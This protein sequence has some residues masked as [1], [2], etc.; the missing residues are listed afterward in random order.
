MPGDG[1]NDAPAL[2]QADC[3]TAFS[4]ATDA[5]RGAAALI[6]AAP[7]LSVIDNAVDEAQL[8]F[9]SSTSYTIYRVALAM[10]IMVLVVLSTIFL[11]F[12]PLTAIMIVIM[13]LL[14]DLPIMTIA[15]DN[16]AVAPRPIRWRMPRLLDVSAVL[17]LASVVQSFGL[18]LFGMAARENEAARSFFE[19]HD[20]SRLQTVM[21]PQLV[22]GGHFLLLV[23]RTQDWFFRPPY[24]AV[25]LLLAMVITQALAVL[26]CGFGWLVPKISWTAIVWFGSGSIFSSGS[27]FSALC[28]SPTNGRSKIGCIAGPAAP[29]SSTRRCMAA[30]ITDTA[31]GRP[32]D[33]PQASDR[34]ARKPCSPC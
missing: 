6:L 15:Y 17:G 28:A 14:D 4:G 20:R 7:G 16:T 5:A 18:L 25:P 19:L 32:H 11:K 12:Q 24:P 30:P 31:G 22:A 21:F 8:I 2:K 1:V 29:R 34:Q 10:D 27:A 13:S 23:T 33:L 3:G 26:M 9:S